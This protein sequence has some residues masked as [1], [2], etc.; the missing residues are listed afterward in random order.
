MAHPELLLLYAGRNVIY[1]I[2]DKRTAAAA[3]DTRVYP[4]VWYSSSSDE[5]AFRDRC[6]DDAKHRPTPCR[7]AVFPT[8]RQRVGPDGPGR[9]DLVPDSTAVSLRSDFYTSRWSPGQR[10]RYDLALPMRGGW[11]RLGRKANDPVTSKHDIVTF[12]RVQT[13]ILIS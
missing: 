3:A 5:N 10:N 11:V 2:T 13:S 9:L 7:T 6:W 1:F 8:T 4:A 12:P